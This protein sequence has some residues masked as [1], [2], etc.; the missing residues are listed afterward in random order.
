MRGRRSSLQEESEIEFEGIAL[1]CCEGTGVLVMASYSLLEFL[2]AGS[3][4]DMGGKLAEDGW[5]DVPTLKVIRAEDMEALALTNAQRVSVS[6]T[7]F[8]FWFHL[9]NVHNHLASACCRPSKPLYSGCS[10]TLRHLHISL[11][12]RASF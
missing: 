2:G 11:E 6:C 5:D 8:M 1:H 10:R 7:D 3:L 4:K 12:H 9:L